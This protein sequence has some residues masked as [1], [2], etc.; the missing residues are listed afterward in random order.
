M[1]H[2]YKKHPYCHVVKKDSSFKKIYNRRIRRRKLECPDGMSYKKLNE[3][4]EIEDLS[5]T[6]TF[7]QYKNSPWIKI[8]NISEEQMYRDWYKYYKSK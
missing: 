4:W 8:K 1:T 2:S 3:S 7:E 6:I 5:D